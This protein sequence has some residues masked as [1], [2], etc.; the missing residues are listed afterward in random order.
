MSDRIRD[1]G[2]T[3]PDLDG[4]GQA[5]ALW[6]QLDRSPRGDLR[7]ADSADLAPAEQFERRGL[8]Q[9]N[10]RPQ[11]APL[12]LD[13]LAPDDVRQGELGDCWVLAPV[14]AIAHTS[15]DAL[16]ER[17]HQRP[18]GTCDVR[19]ADQSGDERLVTISPRF[20]EALDRA[21]GRQIEL[22]ADAETVAWPATV[23]KAIATTHQ[24]GY[25][26]L[27]R[28]GTLDGVAQT[29][30]QVSG[31]PA[32]LRRLEGRT[33]SQVLDDMQSGRPMVVGTDAP[34]TPADQRLFDELDLRPGHAYWVEGLDGAAIR[35]RNP[36]GFADPPRGLTVQELRRVACDDGYVIGGRGR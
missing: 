21:D 27:D 12:G 19:L 3:R 32:E 28:G 8:E 25:A 4:A 29:M 24:G 36:W 20:P 31:E 16:R 11:T 13:R 34:R 33:D 23:E 6:R 35:L 26:T 18:D 9:I 1:V 2:E 7:E 22:H 14:A 15:P 17:I 30:H 10:W 5:E